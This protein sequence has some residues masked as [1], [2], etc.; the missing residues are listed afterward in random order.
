MITSSNEE[1]PRDGPVSGTLSQGRLLITATIFQNSD[2]K[3]SPALGSWFRYVAKEGPFLLGEFDGR[4]I[5]FEEV[6]CGILDLTA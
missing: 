6:A 1:M 3:T 5:L 4:D 2:D